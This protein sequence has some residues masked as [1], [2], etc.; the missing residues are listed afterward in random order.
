MLTEK[1]GGVRE[2]RDHDADGLSEGPVEVIF[3]MRSVTV[4]LGGFA[5]AALA[6]EEGVD[7]AQIPS[8]A[9]Q[10]IRCYLN[11]KGTGGPGWLYPGFMRGGD[12]GDDVEL[13]LSIDGDLWR[14]LEDEAERQGVSAQKM[15]EHAVLYFAAET[16]AGRITRRILDD[17]GED[18]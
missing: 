6:E 14:S 16:D 18:G 4:R 9:V 11:D 10:A 3:M 5:C 12:N 15:V 8:A 17:F 13:Q 7:P 2:S 1:R